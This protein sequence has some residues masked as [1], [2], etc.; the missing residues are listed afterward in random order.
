MINEILEKAVE[1]LKNNIDLELVEIAESSDFGTPRKEGAFMFVNENAESFGTVGG[2]NYEYKCTLYAKEL[3]VKKIDGEKK[4][5]L[6]QEA[7]ENIGMVCGGNSLTKFTYLTNNEKSYN[8]I[9]ELKK[10]K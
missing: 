1:M 4:F 10:K 9:E 7:T 8:I 5:E 6:N 2:G 3:L